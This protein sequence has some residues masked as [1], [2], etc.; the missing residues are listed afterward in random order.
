MVFLENLIEEL[1]IDGVEFMVEVFIVENIVVEDVFFNFNFVIDIDV[2][3][4]LI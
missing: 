4:V 2:L 1:E 3:V